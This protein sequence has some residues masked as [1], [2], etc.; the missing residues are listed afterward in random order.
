MESYKSQQLTPRCT[1]HQRSAVNHCMSVCPSAV[2]ATQ[3]I[4]VALCADVGTSTAVKS[5]GMG[6]SVMPFSYHDIV[7]RLLKFYI[8][9]I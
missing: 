7:H 3:S 6:L 1:P 2:A 9:T 5:D 4:L 8:L